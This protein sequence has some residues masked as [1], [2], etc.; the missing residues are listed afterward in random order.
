[1]VGEMVKNRAKF[2]LSCNYFCALYFI[3]KIKEV[4]F[5]NLHTSAYLNLNYG[6]TKPNCDQY[7]CKFNFDHIFSFTVLSLSAG[8]K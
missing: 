5:K 4:K 2:Y 3:V 8:E 6:A 1:M 7:P